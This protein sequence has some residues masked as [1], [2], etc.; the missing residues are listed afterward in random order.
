MV[1]S[2]W[3]QPKLIIMGDYGPTAPPLCR[4]ITKSWVVG[5]QEREGAL[6]SQMPGSIS[7]REILSLLSP[8]LI[9]PVNIIQG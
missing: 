8:P 1:E 9:L 5:G 4:V 6:D 7:F 2:E 3:R